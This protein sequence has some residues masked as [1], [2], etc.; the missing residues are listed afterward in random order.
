MLDGPTLQLT[1]A[2]SFCA[3]GRFCDPNSTCGARSRKPTI[4]KS[5]TMFI[6]QVNECPSG[7]LVAWDKA[8]GKPVEQALPVSI[9]LI[10]EPR[11]AMQRTAV[12]AD[13]RRG[14]V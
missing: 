3:F 9:G 12:V 6:R 14:R 4:P 1:D 11:A 10:G 5:V 8:S 7:R 2:E 13:R